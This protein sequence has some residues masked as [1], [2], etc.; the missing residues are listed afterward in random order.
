MN[1]EYKSKTRRGP[2]VEPRVRS[3]TPQ[4][5]SSLQKPNIDK[6]R[7]TEGPYAKYYKILDELN[8]LKS[9]ARYVETKPPELPKNAIYKRREGKLLFLG[10][11]KEDGKSEKRNRKAEFCYGKVGGARGN[12]FLY[13][14]QV[15]FD[16]ILKKWIDT[17]EAL[18]KANIEQGI[19]SP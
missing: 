5:K 3:L 14:S 10:L 4:E 6:P 9:K 19:K 2:Y 13:L 1:E 12:L 11:L 18:K 8:E 16:E 17:L 7:V 15:D